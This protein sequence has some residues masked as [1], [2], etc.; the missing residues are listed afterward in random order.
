MLLFAAVKKYRNKQAKE[1]EGHQST[2]QSGQSAFNTGSQP[3]YMT[4][5]T[6]AA[7]QQDQQQRRR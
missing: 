2:E 6:Q 4:K 1:K 5:T 7:S 3:S